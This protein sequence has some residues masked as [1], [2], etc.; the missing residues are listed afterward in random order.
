M[1]TLQNCPY[2]FV[3]ENHP[4]INLLKVNKGVLGVDINDV[5]KMDGEWY[6]LATPLMSSCCDTIRTQILNKF[7]T[8]DTD[9]SQLCI[10]LHRLGEVPWNN[11][12]KADV[13]A[14]FR[15]DPSWSQERLRDE[16]KA[17]EARFLQTPATFMARIQLE[18]ETPQ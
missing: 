18:Y 17:H 6:K 16:V 2:V 3:N 10:Q 11:A 7:K 12:D 14:N 1:L 9:L 13:L 4:V 5:P 8:S 15:S